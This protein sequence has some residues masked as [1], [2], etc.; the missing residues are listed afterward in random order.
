MS[1]KSDSKND[2][3]SPTGI[4][5]KSTKCF[6]EALN[7]SNSSLKSNQENVM[8]SIRIRPL[9]IS[10]LGNN[11]THV[12]D[13]VPGVGGRISLNNVWKEKLNKTSNINEYSFDSV[14]VGSDN[15]GPY[16][17]SVSY[18]VR[19]AMEGYHGTVFAYGQTSSGKTF[20]NIFIVL[21]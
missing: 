9:S 12:W 13:V 10:E 18:V 2:S 11:E 15:S 1:F 3:K 7:K 5:D 20:S 19:S 21:L 16:S 14:F 17:E 4:I 6:N 8:V